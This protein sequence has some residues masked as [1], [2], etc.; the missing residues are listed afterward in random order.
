MPGADVIYN[1]SSFETIFILLN[2]IRMRFMLDH[3]KPSPRVCFHVSRISESLLLTP[4][5][6]VLVSRV[7]RSQQNS[8]HYLNFETRSQNHPTYE[9]HRKNRDKTQAYRQRQ[10]PSFFSEC[11]HFIQRKYEIHTLRPYE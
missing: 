4:N 3:L 10:S 6:V 5:F 9:Q 11:L 7:T 2:V 8:I 1:L